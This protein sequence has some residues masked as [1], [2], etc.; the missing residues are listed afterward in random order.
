MLIR[1]NANQI[2][3]LSVSLL[4][5]KHTQKVILV[6]ASQ[7]FVLFFSK[8]PIQPMI[9]CFFMTGHKWWYVCIFNILCVFVYSVEKTDQ[10]RKNFELFVHLILITSCDDASSSHHDDSCCYFDY[11]SGHKTLCNSVSH[12]KYSNSDVNSGDDI[13]PVCTM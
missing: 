2:A 4:I 11:S 9:L 1:E 10:K 8:R 13:S 6:G 5:S 12:L 3:F 7:Y